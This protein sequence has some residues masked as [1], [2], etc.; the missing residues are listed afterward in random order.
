MN[1]RRAPEPEIVMDAEERF[2]GFENL[3]PFK[4]HNILLVSSFY[5]SFIL[6]EDGR[7]RVAHR[8]IA[9]SHAADHSGITHVCLAPRRRNWP[10]KAIQPDPDQPNRRRHEAAQL[11][12]QVKQAGW[13]SGRGAGLRLSRNQD[14]VAR[15]PVTDIERIFL[16]QGNARIL[17]AIVKHIE[18]QRNVLHDTRT[19]GV[20]CCWW[21]KTIFAI[22]RRSAVIYTE[23]IK[24]SRRVIQ[25]GINVAH[26]LVRLQAR[27]KILLSSNSKMRPRW[28][29]SIATICSAWCRTLNP[30]GRKAES[31]GGLRTGAHGEEPGAGRARCVANQP[32][33]FRPRRTPPGIH[34]CANV[35]QR[36]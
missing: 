4:V 18:D 29:S 24:Q 14:F 6:R 34:F 27:P 28:C 17:I 5:D 15:N 2:E 30:L 36:C 26:K 20:P 12:S 32:R 33:E 11:A 16:W 13:M 7:Q 25:E 31:R 19:I 10:L 3:M 8:P 9:R 1:V 23:L 22:T 21:W 35:R